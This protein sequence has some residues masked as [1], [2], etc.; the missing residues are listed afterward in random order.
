MTQVN[1][2]KVTVATA[3]EKFGVLYRMA[4]A[5]ATGKYRTVPWKA[6]MTILAAVIYFLNPFDLIPDFV[7]LMGLSDDF[8]V[9]VWV[10]S[11]VS[12]EIDKF[13]MWEKETIQS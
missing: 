6:M 11:S 9:L 7:P 3:K 13:L 2:D 12:T 10:Y 1:W 4:S 5:Y 8:G